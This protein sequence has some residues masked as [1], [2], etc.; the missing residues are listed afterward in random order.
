[1]TDHPTTRT[2]TPNMTAEE[3]ALSLG[4]TYRQLDY[5]CRAGYVRHH[6]VS[7]T[8]RTV[9][10]R[11]RMQG[12]RRVVDPAEYPVLRIV[13]SLVWEG[14]VLHVA[15]RVAREITETGVSRLG[16]LTVS[17]GHADTNGGMS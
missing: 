9:K 5:W 8:D 13:G 7:R 11:A 6:H 16:N 4:I 15:F 2:D 10:P 14:V 1:M 17:S 12:Y 3:L